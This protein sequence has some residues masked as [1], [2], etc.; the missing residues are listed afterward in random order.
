MNTNPEMCTALEL[1]ALGVEGQERAVEQY[2]HRA[3]A[4]D[5]FLTKTNVTLKR[6]ALFLMEENPRRWN[7]AE[8]VSRAKAPVNFPAEICTALKRQ[9]HF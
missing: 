7:F 1:G 2:V 3:Q 9:A 5:T 8:N 6:G 4:T